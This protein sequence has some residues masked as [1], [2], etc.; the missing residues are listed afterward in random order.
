M[1]NNDLDPILSIDFAALYARQW[2]RSSFGPRNAAD[3]DRRAS[4]RYHVFKI[5]D[6]ERSFLRHMDLRGMESV[7]DIGCGTG[8]LAVPL[9]RRVKRVYALDF[10]Q[11]MLNFLKRHARE[12]RVRNIQTFCLSWSDSWK[13][14]PKADI[15][16]CS[17]ALSVRDLRSALVKMSR[18]ARRRCYASIH[19]RGNYLSDDVLRLLDHRIVPRPDYIY[20]VN[21]LY[22]LGYRAA[23]AFIRSPGGRSF[24]TQQEFLDSVEW[25]LGP[26]RPAERKRLTAFYENLPIGRDG[27]RHHAHDFEWALLSWETSP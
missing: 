10:S 27:C 14:V 22:Q 8:N 11:S 25:R 16:I 18:H 20:A 12:A 1:T 23:V 7:L 21:I 13:R 17:R 26:L 4:E 9:A 5:G 2:E 15:A 19:A 3:W 24:E 6:Y